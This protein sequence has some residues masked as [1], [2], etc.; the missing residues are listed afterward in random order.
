MRRREFIT[1]LGGAGPWSLAARAQQTTPTIG[2]LH[3]GLP[4]PNAYLVAAFHEGLK[5]S[6]Y[7]EG[8]NASIEYRWAEARWDRLSA[9]AADLVARHV[10]VIVAGG[11]TYA[12][13]AA[14][15]VTETIPIVFVGAADPVKLGLLTNLNRPDGNVTGIVSLGVELVPKRLELLHELVPTG[16]AIGV[17]VNPNTPT[18]DIQLRNLEDAAR[19]LGREIVIASASSK[20]ELDDAFLSFAQHGARALLIVPDT[21]FNSERHKLAALTVDHAIPAI[22]YIREFAEAGGLMSYGVSIVD[23]YRR[24]GG[25]VGRI[26]NGDKPADLPVQQSTKVELIINLRTAKALGLTMPPALIARADEVIE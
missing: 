15:R 1:L 25:Y 22:Y 6:G 19:S 12:G 16:A 14:R 3:T 20:D 7:V 4:R 2:F 17:L 11:G 18:L 13:L 21:L 23:G 24:A 10:T 9:L 8:Q 26:L 5:E